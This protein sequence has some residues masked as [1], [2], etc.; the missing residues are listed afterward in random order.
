M[1]R[2]EE[3]CGLIQRCNQH[4]VSRIGITTT[5]TAISSNRFAPIV[6]LDTNYAPDGFRYTDKREKPLMLLG[7]NYPLETVRFTR[8]GEIELRF[9]VNQRN[10]AIGSGGIW[11]NSPTRGNIR[12]VGCGVEIVGQYEFTKSFGDSFPL[13][14]SSEG[15]KKGAYVDFFANDDDSNILS[16]HVGRVMILGRKIVIV[17]DPGHGHTR[18]D[19]GTSVRLYTHRVREG[20]RD[21]D[22]RVNIHTIPDTAVNDPNTRFATNPANN[23][24]LADS[25][26]ANWNE[27]EI[28]FEL[29][30]QMKEELDKKG[31]YEVLLTR[32]VARAVGR[33]DNEELFRRNR[34]ANDNNADYFI[35]L[36]LE[37]DPNDVGARGAFYMYRDNDPH[38]SYTH[39]LGKDLTRYLRPA[40]SGSNDFIPITDARQA[41][42]AIFSSDRRLGNHT[43]HKALIEIG[44]LTNPFDARI[45]VEDEDV[46]VRARAEDRVIEGRGAVLSAICEQLLKGLYENIERNF[47]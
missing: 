1:G 36:H 35:S 9:I 15:L 29:A 40:I 26:Y 42:L 44:T 37:G 17:I 34:F 28:V 18:G 21:V 23:E 14:L 5:Q 47:G 32:Q 12:A 13:T 38:L 31:C 39:A 8:D 24:I 7:H 30:T 25:R 43:K 2:R 19:T 22:K 27:R 46:R 33:D 10:S 45:L 3:P 16:V 20:E 6:E 41:R 4:R 11:D